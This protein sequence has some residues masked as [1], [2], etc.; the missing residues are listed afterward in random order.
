MPEPN[1][2]YFPRI[3]HVFKLKYAETKVQKTFG[4]FNVFPE[5]SRAK[6]SSSLQHNFRAICS[7]FLLIPP[8]SPVIPLSN[9]GHNAFQ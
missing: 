2:I 6:L 9:S 1:D 5:F 7:I 8:E 3:F 4:I